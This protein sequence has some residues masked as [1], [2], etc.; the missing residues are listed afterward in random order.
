MDYHKISQINKKKWIKYCENHINDFSNEKLHKLPKRSDYNAVL[1]EFRPMKHLEYII[2]RFIYYLGTKWM[3]T[4]VCGKDNY[5]TITNIV[6]KLSHNITIVNLNISVDSVHKYNNLL[7]SIDFWEKLNGV[8]ILIHQEDSMIFK[9]LDD[10]FLKYDYIGAP[11]NS[12]YFQITKNNVGNGG[13][14][15][16]SKE[17]IIHILK[18]YDT[19]G[20]IYDNFTQGRLDNKS[21]SVVPED[22]F[23][24]TIMKKYNIGKISPY[25]VATKFCVEHI[26]DKESTFGH[27]WWLSKGIHRVFDFENCELLNF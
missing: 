10:T 11:W 17:V 19:N 18:N 26:Y 2:R 13:L 16:R 25:E 23:I 15:L 8:K 6:N 22:V 1:I 24:V 21:I 14:S 27:Q 7:L 3:Y 9:H 4:I 12:K 20:E 5:D